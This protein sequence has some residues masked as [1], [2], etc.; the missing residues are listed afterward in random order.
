MSPQLKRL[1]KRL[2]KDGTYNKPKRWDDVVLEAIDLGIH[3]ESEQTRG[4]PR[5]YFM[6]EGE[7][8]KALKLIKEA[9]DEQR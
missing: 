6:D 5:Y 1:L 3:L 7:R 2:I 9:H 4:S 8:E